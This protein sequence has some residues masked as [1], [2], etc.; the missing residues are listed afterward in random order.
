MLVVVL[1]AAAGMHLLGPAV[2]WFAV[3]HRFPRWDE[4]NVPLNNVD[5]VTG[6]L[7][8]GASVVVCTTPG[9]DVVPRLRSFV[10][11]FATLVTAVAGFF[12]VQTLTSV[13]AGDTFFA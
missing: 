7:V 3:N 9:L 13:S 5:S 10:R 12:V 8:L 11:G 6:L 4:L 2:R 1:V